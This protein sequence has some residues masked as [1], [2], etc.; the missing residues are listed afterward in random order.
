VESD[1]AGIER[2]DDGHREDQEHDREEHSQ[3]RRKVSPRRWCDRG[4]E[5]NL[6]KGDRTMKHN[7]QIPSSPAWSTSIER[8]DEGHPDEWL[9]CTHRVAYIP[10]GWTSERPEGEDEPM[11]VELEAHRS[12]NPDG[13]LPDAIRVEVPAD[14]FGGRYMSAASA[15]KFAA[16]LTEAANILTATEVA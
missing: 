15:R 10:E 12:A 6:N 9:K 3:G 8:N 14:M 7:T 13:M 1:V 2:E 5:F 11:L 4:R 16:A